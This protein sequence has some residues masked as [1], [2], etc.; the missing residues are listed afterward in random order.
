MEN[1]TEFDFSEDAPQ[2]L[3]QLTLPDLLP[4]D[5][6]NVLAAEFEADYFQSLESFLAEEYQQK[7][8]FPTRENLFTAFRIT[9]FDDVKV[10]L[11]GQDPYHDNGQAHG[12]SFSVLPGVKIPPSLR[13]MYKELESDLGIEP[14]DHGYLE[15]WAQQ[16][17]LM[18]NAVLT[19]EAHKANSHKNK[20]WEQ[21]TDAVITSLAEREKP[22]VFLLWGGF[23]KK[24][25][26]LI[27]QHTQ[28]TIIEGTHPSPL[29]AHSGFWD[30]K[31]YSMVNRT[32]EKMNQE[33]I[34][35]KIDPID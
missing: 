2:S 15:Q 25:A 33:P 12:L 4:A 7:E 30:S 3:S 28:H 24:K 18:L 9:A 32:L 26:K 17:V 27:K 23:A 14:P 13:N 5:W 6:R 20:G 31:P 21:F 16:G 8:V 11:L 34:D 1:Q 10:L 29:S 35:W 22:M 19:V